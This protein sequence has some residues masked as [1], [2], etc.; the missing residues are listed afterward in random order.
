MVWALG[1]YLSPSPMLAT[2]LNYFARLMSYDQ[3]L[4]ATG[5]IVVSLFCAIGVILD[6]KKQHEFIALL[7]VIPQQFVML[8]CAFGS[9]MSIVN[10]HY[11]DG[12]F[13]NQAFILADQ[14]PFIIAAVMYTI[15][16]LKN[17]G[18]NLFWKHT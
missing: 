9:V 2:P 8:V 18:N 14:F 4:T 12:V 7:C 16:I 15:S 6:Q 1:L 13:R 17:F 3:Y 5:L 11:A 10:S